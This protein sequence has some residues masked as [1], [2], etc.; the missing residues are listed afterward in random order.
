VRCRQEHLTFVRE[1]RLVE[2]MLRLFIQVIF[3]TN[4][5]SVPLFFVCLPNN[6]IIIFH[7]V[8]KLQL[9]LNMF[10]KSDV[11]VLLI[12]ENNRMKLTQYN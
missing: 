8:V 9:L 5:I 11:C 6:I 1:E 7:N 10:I 12:S 2:I 4:S 3:S